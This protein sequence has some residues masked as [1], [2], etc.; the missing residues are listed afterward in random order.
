MAGGRID[1]TA[2]ETSDEAYAER[3]AAYNDQAA[4]ATLVNRYRTRLTALARRL[5]GTLQ[6]EAEDIAQ[7]VFVAAYQARGRYRRGEVFRAWLYRIA[8][9]R[10]IDRRRAT[11]R[12]PPPL[13]MLEGSIGE[14]IDSADGP[15]DALLAGEREQGIQAAVDALPDRYRAV[16]LLRHLDD[17]SY[18]EIATATDLPVGTVKTH[19]FRARAQLREELKGLLET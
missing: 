16:F 14:A 11:D 1:T 13:P 8:I 4:F 19:L 18:E 2:N 12:R 15:L 5:L 17:L 9:N 6:N 7:E 10:C 3:V